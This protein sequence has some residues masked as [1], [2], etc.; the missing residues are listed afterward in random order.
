MACLSRQLSQAVT[1][2][3]SATRS[4]EL[5]YSGT[6]AGGAD[7]AGP[8]TPAAVLLGLTMGYCV[9]KAGHLEWEDTSVSPVLGRQ[10]VRGDGTQG[11]RGQGRVPCPGISEALPLPGDETVS[12]LESGFRFHGDDAVGEHVSWGRPDSLLC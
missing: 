3:V 9:W 5:A 2:S 10:E 11:G 1:Q 4:Q 8:G 12:P 6:K 7:D